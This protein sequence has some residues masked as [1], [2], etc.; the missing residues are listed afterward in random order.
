MKIFLPTNLPLP[1]RIPLI[2]APS[3]RWSL[4]MEMINTMTIINFSALRQI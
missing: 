2:T 3:L 1:D 4:A